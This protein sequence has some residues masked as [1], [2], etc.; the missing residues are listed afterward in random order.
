MWLD[1][2]LCELVVFEHTPALNLLML[3][4]EQQL[5][6]K[7]FFHCFKAFSAF[8]CA[9]IEQMEIF[10]FSATPPLFSVFLCD[11]S[12]SPMSLTSEAELGCC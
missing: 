3:P 8:I 11:S 7:A 5:T 10:D 1:H 2:K 4:E 6:I 12:G 9:Q